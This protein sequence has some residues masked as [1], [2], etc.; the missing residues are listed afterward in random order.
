[1]NTRAETLK[2]RFV[3]NCKIT[4]YFFKLP[5]TMF[6]T[7]MAFGSP[8]NAAQHFVDFRLK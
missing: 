4:D 2:S 5:V 7:V 3:S 1:M 6:S 8:A